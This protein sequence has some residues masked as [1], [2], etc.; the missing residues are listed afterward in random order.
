MKIILTHDVVGLGEPGDVVEV[1][2]GYARNYLL[3]QKLAIFATRGAER[4][5][6]QIKRARKARQVRGLD[7][8][9]EIKSRLT[10]LQI[11]LRVRAGKEGRLFGS[12]TSADVA[13]AVVDA[14]GPELDRR[15]I[16]ISSPIKSTGQHTVSVAL[17][18]DVVA[19]FGVEVVPVKA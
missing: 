4:Q 12:V 18:P 15:R 17:H 5:A 7:H 6:E 8:A 2:D 1:K 9:N 19:S 10:A 16:Q 3:P 13:S 11:R 14:G